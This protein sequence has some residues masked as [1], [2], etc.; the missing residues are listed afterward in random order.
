MSHNSS[1]IKIFDISTFQLADTKSLVAFKKRQFNLTWNAINFSQYVLL[2]ST[3]T[4]Y[5]YRSSEREE[6]IDPRDTQ[7]SKGFWSSQDQSGL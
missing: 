3:W 1:K 2:I 6:G 5:V 4:G 7:R